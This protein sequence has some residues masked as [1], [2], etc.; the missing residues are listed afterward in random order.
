MDEV[1]TDLSEKVGKEFLYA[2]WWFGVV[3]KQ[4]KDVNQ[5]YVTWKSALQE[6]RLSVNVKRQ[7]HFVLDKEYHQKCQYPRS[8]CGIGV[9]RNSICCKGCSKWVHK[10]VWILK[11]LCQQS[12]ILNAKKI[13]E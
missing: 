3:G 1:T 8:E 12:R 2:C 13:M 4:Q 5:Q 10:S 7:K 6:K 9:G 11:V